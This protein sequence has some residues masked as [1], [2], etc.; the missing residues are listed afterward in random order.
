MFLTGFRL[1]RYSSCD[2][3]SCIH[4]RVGRCIFGVVGEGV[5]AKSAQNRRA[6]SLGY[7]ATRLDKCGI[8]DRDIFLIIVKG[9]SLFPPF[10]DC[11][12]YIK[13]NERLSSLVPKT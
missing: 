1:F 6:L 13:L 3:H 10:H 2:C 7:E 12:Q 4:G 8:F 11:Q 5:L 9:L